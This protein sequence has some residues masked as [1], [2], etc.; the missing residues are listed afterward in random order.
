MPNDKYFTSPLEANLRPVLQIL[1]SCVEVE[2]ILD[3]HG[4]RRALKTAIKA[5]P[6]DVGNGWGRV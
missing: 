4:L 5:A 3:L 1:K 2:E 6:S